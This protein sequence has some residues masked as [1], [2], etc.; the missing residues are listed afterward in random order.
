MACINEYV[1]RKVIQGDEL[2]FTQLYNHYKTPATKFCVSLIKE[3]EEAENMVHDVFIKIWEKRG[4]INPDLNFNSYLFTCLRNLAFDYFKK[5]EK[6]QT[7]R[8]EY[9]DR[10]EEAYEIAP[11]TE[12]AKIVLLRAGIEALSEKRKQILKLNVE[13]GKSYQEIAELMR[14]SKNTVKN[15]LVKAKQFL[16]DRVDLAAAL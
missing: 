5:V 10:M 3:E 6:N 14:I 12:E 16:R 2:A 4:Q 7:L 1:L 9:F 15:Q 13:E 8:Q 11:D